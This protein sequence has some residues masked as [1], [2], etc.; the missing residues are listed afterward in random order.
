MSLLPLMQCEETLYASSPSSSRRRRRAASMTA[1]SLRRLG[2][3]TQ[4]RLLRR[5][6]LM[7]AVWLCG[8]AISHALLKSLPMQQGHPI[9]AAW[10]P[11]Y[12][13][14]ALVQSNSDGSTFQK[15]SDVWL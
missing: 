13:Y 1:L 7:C 9:A 11:L 4:L 2:W 6:L 15:S 5:S 3:Q 14:C 12:V 8:P 10:L